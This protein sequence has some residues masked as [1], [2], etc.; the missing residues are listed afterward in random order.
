VQGTHLRRIGVVAGVVLALGGGGA[1]LAANQL[2]SGSRDG[3]ELPLRG[4]LGPGG[5]GEG[6]G[7]D[8]AAEYLG[9]SEAE[10]RAELAEGNSLA[11]IAGEQ[12][13]SVD[14]LIDAMVEASEERLDAAVEAGRLTEAQRDALQDDLRAR[15]TDL[16]NGELRL[17]FGRGGGSPGLDGTTT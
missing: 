2:D 14:G 4:G 12:D 9:L 5:C 11:E 15:V 17:R 13:K 1:A 8:A 10:L 16:V 3:G 7:L 6:R